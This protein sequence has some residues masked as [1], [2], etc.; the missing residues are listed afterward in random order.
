MLKTLLMSLLG[1]AALLGSLGLG[2]APARAQI[3]SAAPSYAGRPLDYWQDLLAQ[4]VDKDSNED[5]E[6]CRRAAQALGQFGPQA[7]EAIPLL[8]QT[9]QSPS[10]EA[11]GCAVDALGRIGL[12]A[13]AAVPAIIAEVDLPKDHINYAPLA[14]FRRVA[15]RALGRIGIGATA[16]IPVLE[17][18]LQN[19]D[20]LYRVQAALALWSIASHPQAVPTLQAA[21]KLNDREAVFDAVQAL[22]QIGP[23]ATAAA[24]DLVAALAHEDPDVRRAAADVLV[25]LGPSQFE[26]IAQPL[27]E[28]RIPSPAAAAYALGEISD[29]M[30]QDVF[31]DPRLDAQG[32]AAAA[33]PVIRL[34]GPA[35]TGLLG[36]ADP[37]VRQSAVQALS[38]M[39][40][41]A[42]P[43]LLQSLKADDAVVR[44]AAI[45]GLTRLEAHLPNASPAG[46]GLE[47]FKA[48]L[49]P[50][51]MDLMKHT[52]PQV[53]RAAYRAF[54]KFAFD[55]AGQAAAPLL[56]S[57]LRDQD[58]S[59]RRYAF[60]ALQ[61]QG[62]ERKW[63]SGKG[64]E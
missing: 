58:L 19:E 17:K 42:A 3:G 2:A 38:Q 13:Q 21:L 22:G 46:P 11:R 61:Q 4:H 8:T 14:D 6:Q 44:S 39:G 7:K 25:K 18:A 60:E 43:F 56:R 40:L 32:L 5:K 10:R 48:N 35:L 57:A 64:E 37:E 20:P 63:K 31:Y 50:R 55:A 51:L 1:L 30:R 16:A 47:V 52:D 41:L 27:S 26:S 62:E 53:R 49:V 28:G 54:A 45:A 29:R 23:G 15:A 34:A 12:D 59:V 33:R 9:L 36:H 24:P